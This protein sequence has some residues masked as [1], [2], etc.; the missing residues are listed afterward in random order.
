MSLDHAR[1][2]E[3]KALPRMGARALNPRER[4]ET[5]VSISTLEIEALGL[6]SLGLIISLLGLII[7]GCGPPF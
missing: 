6:I 1:V 7:G 2:W 3:M 5:S 4:I